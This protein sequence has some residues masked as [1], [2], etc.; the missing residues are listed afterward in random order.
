MEIRCFTSYFPRSKQHEL[1]P[2]SH[3]VPYCSQEQVIPCCSL[4]PTPYRGEQEEQDEWR[5][6]SF[7]SKDVVPRILTCQSIQ[8]EYPNL[9]VSIKRLMPALIANG[10]SIDSARPRQ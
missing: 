6:E 7:F 5:G 1:V 3:V 8:D 2:Y 4:V 9:F 10:S